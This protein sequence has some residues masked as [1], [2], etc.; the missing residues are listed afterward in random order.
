MLLR[1]S[2]GLLF[3]IAG[4]SAWVHVTDPSATG[5]IGGDVDNPT[6][7]LNNGVKMPLVALGTWQYNND[8]AEDAIKL[9]LSLGF[10]HIDT[11][12]SYH[13]QAR[14]LYHNQQPCACLPA[15]RPDGARLDSTRQRML[16]L[17][18]HTTNPGRLRQGSLGRAA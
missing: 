5:A 9:A 3:L 2:L 4:A 14:I 12:E 8:V 1:C 13:N 11:A 17:R 10:T 18:P 6:I 15:G 16:C 7:T